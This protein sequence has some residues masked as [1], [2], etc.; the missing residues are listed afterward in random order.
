MPSNGISE[1][2]RIDGRVII[3]NQ[4]FKE[5]KRSRRVGSIQ[6]VKSLEKSF[7]RFGMKPIVLP[8]LKYEEIVN[9]VH[10]CK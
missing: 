9:E 7:G 6:D 4:E 3:M 10:A 5:I 8:D 1:Q 2:V